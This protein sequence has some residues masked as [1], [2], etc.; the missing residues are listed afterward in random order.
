MTEPSDAPSE[1]RFLIDENVSASAIRV[2]RLYGRELLES[3]DVTGTQSP[4][5]I[6]EW[7]AH[8]H[9]CIL[10]SRDRDFKA[11]IKGVKARELQKTAR[12]IILRGNEVTEADRLQQCLPIIEQFFRNATVSG[13]DI[14]FIQLMEDD[15]N[16]KYRIPDLRNPER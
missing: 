15:I 9:Q 16:V 3:R 13:L 8:T 6:L 2:L 4:D 5:R 1:F 14:E 12:T 7:V 11:I 10:V